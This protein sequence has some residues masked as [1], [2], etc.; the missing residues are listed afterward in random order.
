MRRRDD[1]H[2]LVE[3]LCQVAKT[4]GKEGNMFKLLINNV[5]GPFRAAVLVE[6]ED[7]NGDTVG[8]IKLMWNL[9]VEEP[10]AELARKS[11]ES[12]MARRSKGGKA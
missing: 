7:V 6:K 8:F 1:V 4:P 3:R 11:T 2:Y 12:S 10:V 5:G 9:K